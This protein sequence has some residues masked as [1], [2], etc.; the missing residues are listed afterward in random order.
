MMDKAHLRDKTV[1]F[2]IINTNRVHV[3]KV[4]FVEPD[5][6]WIEVSSLVADLEQDLAW[7]TAVAEVE[8]PLVFFIPISSLMFLVATQ[9]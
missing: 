1:A 4:T 8:A 6:F 9:K 7:R 3:G 2:R 5:G